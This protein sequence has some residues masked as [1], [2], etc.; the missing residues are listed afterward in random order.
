MAEL[1]HWA[2]VLLLAL[3]CAVALAS[4]VLGLP[5]TFLIVLAGLVYAW[6]T[7]FAEV[8]WATLAG[9][10][11]LALLAELIEFASAAGGGRDPALRPS[12]RITLSAIAGAI[13]GA[14]AG[15]PLL[16]G[17]GA[18]LGAF[19]GAFGGAALAAASE[20][21]DRGTAMRHGLRALRGRVLGFV[22]KAALATAMTIW[23]LVSAL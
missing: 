15:A 1:A 16:L 13:V 17:L 4:L 7:G 9:L 21:H 5:G 2:G 10:A 20:G 11:A 23:L 14:I 22:V 19:A 12:R 18:L 6:L 3:V 8:T